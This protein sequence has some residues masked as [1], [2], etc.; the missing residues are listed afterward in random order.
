MEFGKHDSLF[1]LKH[2]I[3]NFIDFVK[4]CFMQDCYF[5]CLIKLHVFLFNCQPLNQRISRSREFGL[6]KRWLLM[7]DLEQREKRRE[8]KLSSNRKVN[9]HP[10]H[11]L[12]ILNIFIFW[13]GKKECQIFNLFFIEIKILLSKYI[14][15]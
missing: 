4:K 10:L 5:L 12:D 9:L 13:L 3:F 7:V 2:S 1:L 11:S 15:S 6:E 14:R 8:T